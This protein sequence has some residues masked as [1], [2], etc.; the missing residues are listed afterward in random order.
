MG[1]RENVIK[2]RALS[3]L[4]QEEFG[5][6]A[7]VTRAAVSQWEGGFSEPRMGAIEKLAKH[8]NIPKSWIIEDEGMDFVYPDGSGQLV[9]KIITNAHFYDD[10]PAIQE[11]LSVM[12]RIFI[13]LNDDSRSRA[14][15]FLQGLLSSQEQRLQLEEQQ[16]GTN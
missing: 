16:N 4:T 14:I 12:T 15:G 2:L 7:G 8:F 5:K 3:T 11:Q 1:V 13:K 10:D 9:H 6:I